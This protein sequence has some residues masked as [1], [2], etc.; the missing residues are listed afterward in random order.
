MT[1]ASA[2]PRLRH[3]LREETVSAILEA[4][5]HEFAS[6]GLHAARMERIAARAG[7]AVGTLYNHFDDREALV[8]ALVAP[9]ARR[10]SWRAWT[11]RSPR[12]RARTRSRPSCAHTSPRSWST[13][14][15]T[16]AS[17][18]AARPGRRGSRAARGRPR[19]CSTSSPRGSG[20]HRARG[21]RGGAPARTTA[22][23]FGCALVGMARA[24][25][26]RAIE[27]ERDPTFA[28]RATR[29]STSSFG[30]RAR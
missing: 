5:E 9:A 6:D 17:C 26:L 15:R 29:S 13:L 28:R 4:A 25:L 27:R 12:S 19:P 14:A 11:R 21:R 18:A 7:V 2:P 3:R 22:D 30:G 8:L 16:A 10:R 23:V 1:R 24:V 20:D